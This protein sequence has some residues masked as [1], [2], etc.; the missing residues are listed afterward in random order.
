MK[1]NNALDKQYPVYSEYS[2][3]S[4]ESII[5]EPVRLPRISG[6]LQVFQWFNWALL[7]VTSIA[8]LVLTGMTAA[9][10]VS[11]RP[12][13]EFA[14]GILQLL[15]TAIFAGYTLSLLQRPS[16]EIPNEMNKYLA[17][18]VGASIWVYGIL[19]YASNV[20]IFSDKP[21]TVVGCIIYYVVCTTYLK[22]SD[23]VKQY[24]G[25]N[26]TP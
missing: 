1:T 20:G 26:A 8:A 2:V 6:S 25:R 9:F 10:F 19:Y 3:D 23:S 4:T 14:G 22:R 21:M 15:P 24:F 17:A 5:T 12:F 11:E 7:L 18:Y 16:G 13:I